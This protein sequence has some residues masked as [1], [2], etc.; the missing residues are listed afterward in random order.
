MEFKPEEAARQ[1][2]GRD[3]GY[4]G[5]EDSFELGS[6]DRASVALPSSA[7]RPQS[8]L[9]MLDEEARAFIEDLE[10]KCSNLPWDMTQGGYS[11]T[12]TRS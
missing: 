2:L 12:L 3:L 5:G 1:L 10:G 9:G 7:D 6:F 11:L 8:C 4:T